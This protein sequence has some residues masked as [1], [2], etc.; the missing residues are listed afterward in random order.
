ML[1]YLI[2]IKE[3]LISKEFSSIFK[4]GSDRLNGYENVHFMNG[5]YEARS[6][7]LAD[8]LNAKC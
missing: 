2:K 8:E 6:S 7:K 3:P 1:L 5:N 4:P